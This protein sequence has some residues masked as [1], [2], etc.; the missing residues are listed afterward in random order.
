[1][2]ILVSTD[3][4]DAP[5]S[6]MGAGKRLAEQVVGA[7]QQRLIH[8]CP[9][10]ELPMAIKS[11]RFGNV[12]DSSGSVI[13]RFRSQ[14]DQGGPVTITHPEARRFFMSVE[15]AVELILHAAVSGEPGSISMLDMGPSI[16]IEDLARRMIHHAGFT[17][18]DSHM[19]GSETEGTIEIVYTGLRPGER[20]QER[21]PMTVAPTTDR[22]LHVPD[23]PPPWIEIET[24]LTR[25]QQ[26]IDQ[27]DADA[28][29]SLLVEAVVEYPC[30]DAPAQ[31]HFDS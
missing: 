19:A 28:V 13:P 26:A 18:G 24:I 25:L 4:A 27:R 2:F 31:Y 5:A 8:Q 3:K 9:E 15:E 17:V 1:M 7:V 6:V 14:I 21:L 12:V 23:S 16:G 30:V 11:V 20:L 10:G 29:R 22:L